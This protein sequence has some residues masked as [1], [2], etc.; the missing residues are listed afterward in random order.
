MFCAAWV[1]EYVPRHYNPTSRSHR[2]IKLGR[3]R[4]ADAR[5]APASRSEMTRAPTLLRPPGKNF[6]I[7]F[8]PARHALTLEKQIRDNTAAPRTRIRRSYS[9]R[10]RQDDF[11]EPTNTFRER[12][13]VRLRPVCP[14]RAHVPLASVSATNADRGSFSTGPSMPPLVTC[15]QTRF[16]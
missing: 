10:A 7:A 8:L 4:N 12:G 16:R 15:G 3:L 11:L 9:P 1:E 6:R 2:P 13:P 5:G 14:L